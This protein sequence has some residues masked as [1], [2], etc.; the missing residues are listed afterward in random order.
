[1]AVSREQILSEVYGYD[2]DLDTGRVDVLVRRLREKLGK[3]PGR[4]SQIIAVPG[5]G[6][7]LDPR[8][9]ATEETS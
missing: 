1:M 6:F 7:R 5:Y 2:E 3:G 4:S 9:V 8:P